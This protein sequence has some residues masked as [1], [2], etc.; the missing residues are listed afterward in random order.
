M[1]R[2]ITVALLLL[3]TGAPATVQDR[4]AHPTVDLRGALYRAVFASATDALSAHDVAALPADVRT[5]VSQFLTR[6]RTLEQAGEG[7]PPDPRELLEHSIVALVDREDARALAADFLREAPVAGGWGDSAAAPLTEASYAE[8]RLRLDAPLAPFLY[9]FIAQ[10]QRAAFELADRAK[11]P[12]TMKA[13]ARK[14]RAVMQ[15]A[16]SAAD[17]IYGLLADDLDRMPYVYASTDKHPAT[18]NPDT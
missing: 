7:T 10:R 18:F 14:Y 5:R 6:R 8:K 13:A 16:R 15:R 9:V 4:L 11:D 12:E 1:L 3:A 17:P 2:V